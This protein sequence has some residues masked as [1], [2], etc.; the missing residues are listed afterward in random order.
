MGGEGP[1]LYY[2]G[3]KAVLEAYAR[4]YCNGFCYCSLSGSYSDFIIPC[5]LNI[6]GDLC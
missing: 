2:V 4:L 5:F 3:G 1:R 6:Y